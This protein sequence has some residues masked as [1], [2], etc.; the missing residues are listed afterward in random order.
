MSVPPKYGFAFVQNY[1]QV[2]PYRYGVFIEQP[3]L[4]L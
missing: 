1:T 4:N 3:L 2:A